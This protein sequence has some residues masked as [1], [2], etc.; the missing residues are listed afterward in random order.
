MS[1][2]INVLTRPAM[3]LLAVLISVLAM[4]GMGISGASAAPGDTTG[5]IIKIDNSLHFVTGA[6][7]RAGSTPSTEY[8]ALWSLTDPSGI[9]SES[10]YIFDETI[11]LE[12]LSFTFVTS[13]SFV[14][15][16]SHE[17]GIDI[18]ATDCSP[19]QN[20][21]HTR[22]LFNTTTTVQEGAASF[23]AGWSTA[24][25]TCFSGGTV[26]YSSKVGASASFPY[27]GYA[28]AF[29]TEYNTNLGT[30]EIY[31]DG[32]DQGLLNAD[33]SHATPRVVGYQ[34]YFNANQTHTLTIVV[35][36]GRINVDAFMING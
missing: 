3:N 5:P 21:S 11:N 18:S 16:T 1:D 15:P 9:C 10:G 34:A 7:L 25:C 12:L 4:L 14:V 17:Y 32:V 23:S 28:M 31:L 6:Q 24:R 29:V 33:T 30:A 2:G 35:K 20:T 8:Q 22:H 36:S 26:R 27:S 19:N 13:E